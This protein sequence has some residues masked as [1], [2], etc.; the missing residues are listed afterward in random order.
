VEEEIE[1]NDTDQ[2][3]CWQTIMQASHEYGRSRPQ[4]AIWYFE[5]FFWIV[6]YTAGGIST[7]IFCYRLIQQYNLGQTQFNVAI[8]FNKSIILPDARLCFSLDR[9]PFLNTWNSKDWGANMLLT[10]ELETY[11][12]ETRAVS[13]RETFLNRNQKWPESLV[14]ASYMYVTILTDYEINIG[15]IF[16]RDFLQ[17]N[18]EDWNCTCPY[19]PCIEC[20]SPGRCSQVKI[21][22]KV[23]HRG[24]FLRVC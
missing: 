14:Y 23:I 5:K 1:Q 16:A 12:E 18:I 2:K 19:P 3:N 10:N 11:F 22:L 15:G 7:A 8:L 20:Y 4:V 24:T 21:A 13:N 6:I 17:L 9:G